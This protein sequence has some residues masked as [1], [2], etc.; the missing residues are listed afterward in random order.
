[1]KP[2]NHN[3]G[4]ILTFGVPTTVVLLGLLWLL[5]RSRD[6]DDD[7]AAGTAK[8]KPL[9]GDASEKEK[10]SISS[11]HGATGIQDFTEN[12][13]QA[14]GDVAVQEK[15]AVKSEVR[16]GRANCS[17]DLKKDPQQ[18]LKQRYEVPTRPE[19]QSASSELNCLQGVSSST[20]TDL[21]AGTSLSDYSQSICRPLA[22]EE[23]VAESFSL[24]SDYFSQ[25]S[26]LSSVP[27][28]RGSAAESHDSLE[29]S[30]QTEWSLLSKE[31]A[32]SIEADTKRIVQASEKNEVTATVISDGSS[33]NISMQPTSSQCSLQSDPSGDVVPKEMAEEASAVCSSQAQ[34]QPSGVCPSSDSPAVVGCSDSDHLVTGEEPDPSDQEPPAVQE[35]VTENYSPNCQ[36]PVSPASPTVS[37]SDDTQQLE[38]PKASTPSQ[39]SDRICESPAEDGSTKDGVGKAPLPSAKKLDLSVDSQTLGSEQPELNITENKSPSAVEAS[40]QALVTEEECGSSRVCDVQSVESASVPSIAS[41]KDSSL[42]S[43]SEASSSLGATVST[44]MSS[45]STESAEPLKSNSSSTC[46]ELLSADDQDSDARMEAS[47]T[48]NQKLNRAEERDSNLDE[49]SSGSNK[50]TADKISI[51]SSTNKQEES[52]DIIGDQDSSLKQEADDSSKSVISPAPPADSNFNCNASATV[53]DTTTTKT[54]NASHSVSGKKTN[55]KN[56][57]KASKNQKS[58]SSP[59]KSTPPHSKSTSPNSKSE[60]SPSKPASS[61]PSASSPASASSSKR[62]NPSAPR[63]GTSESDGVGKTPAGVSENGRMDTGSPICDSNSEASN[64]SGRGGSVGDTLVPLPA[65]DVTRYEFNFPSELCGRLIGRGGKNIQY[66][67][68]QSG[69]TITLTSNPFTPEFQICQ[70]QGLQGEVDR[71]LM[72]IRKKF[73]LSQYPR[74][75]M[76]CL[77]PSASARVVLPEVMQLS[78]PE[79]VSID[80]VVSAVVDAGHIFIQQPTHPTFPSL[81]RLSHFMNVCYGDPSAPSLPRPV[82]EGIICVSESEGQWYRAQI[83][84]VYPVEDECSLKYVDY[85]GYARVAISTL[86]QIRSDFMTLPFQAVECYLANVTP[87]QDEEYYSDKAAEVLMELTSGQMLQG[88]VVARGEDSVGFVHLYRVSGHKVLMI[89][90]EMVNREVVRWIEIL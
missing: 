56:T 69:A 38:E 85:G 64:D 36:A 75:D 28:S 37:S 12:V 78:L 52:S 48:E 67:K 59:S 87:L 3:L 84:E 63:D 17:L 74:L 44:S 21:S 43:A 42:F 72:M 47:T 41:E 89:N 13:M 66:I 81:E 76:T 60:Q 58:A 27:S 7:D 79:G 10:D 34:A 62:K 49:S 46:Q 23:T 19:V 50:G 26:V 33:A 57:S 45:S 1:M 35:I 18:L 39:E 80:V 31:P 15:D 20:S 30:S 14:G 55:S 70:V 65:G 29:L 2:L 68:D 73:P 9:H 40:E 8:E 53:A 71:A 86:K 32:A 90:R 5:R 82:E 16:S 51:Q 83:V 22:A 4:I 77:T 88:Q 24:T 54:G 61:S 11:T 25:T 6:E